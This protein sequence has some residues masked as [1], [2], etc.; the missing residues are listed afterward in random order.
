[1]LAE[2][3]LANFLNEL[4]A[5]APA[6]GGGSA[7]ALSGALGSALL[8]MVCRLTI[9][10]KGYEGVSAEL[11]EILSLAENVRD[12]FTNLIAQDADAFDKVMQAYKLPKE[13]E[14]E[15]NKRKIGVQEALKHATQVPLEVMRLSLEQLKF[16][17][18]V[19]EKGNPSAIS[20]IGCAC[21]S[22]ENAL[23]CAELNIKV[24]LSS[25]K[26]EKFIAQAK[27]ELKNLGAESDK[28]KTKIL[29]LVNKR[30]SL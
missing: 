26:D 24:N 28:L 20:D 11:E 19:A 27:A 21:L 7:A 6:P 12:K 22:L 2:K 30:I 17:L 23:K 16:A 15:K 29:A 4:S 3:S 5:S 10:K 13:S 18:V 1:M 25:I 8:A 9:G 14:E